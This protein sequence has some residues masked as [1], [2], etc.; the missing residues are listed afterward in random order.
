MRGKSASW[1]GHRRVLGVVSISLVRT[2][3]HSNHFLVIEVGVY[4]CVRADVVLMDC[5][6]AHH[7]GIKSVTSSC[8]VVV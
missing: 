5:Q 3:L 1:L 6:G 7:M 4:F 8:P 2:H